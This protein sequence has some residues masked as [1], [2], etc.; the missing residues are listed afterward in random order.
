MARRRLCGRPGELH[1][2]PLGDDNEETCLMEET[3]SRALDLRDMAQDDY[4]DG[5]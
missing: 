1:A 3:A 5:Q 4:E 2:W